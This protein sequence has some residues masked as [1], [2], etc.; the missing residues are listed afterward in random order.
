MKAT[1]LLV[2]AL[3]RENVR[4][5]FGVPGRPCCCSQHLSLARRERLCSAYE[6]WLS[7][8]AALRQHA[9]LTPGSPHQ[10]MMSCSLL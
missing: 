8:P 4:Y 2:K 5:I 6:A 7:T 1:D 10:Y 3:E 9:W